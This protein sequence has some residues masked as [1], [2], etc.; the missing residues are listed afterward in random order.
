MQRVSPSTI[1]A[2][3]VAE[4]PK[5]PHSLGFDCDPE[6]AALVLGAARGQVP[7]PRD[8]SKHPELF[9]MLMVRA[10]CLHGQLDAFRDLLQLSE[11][12]G[13]VKY[14]DAWTAA[15]YYPGGEALE[16]LLDARSFPEFESFWDAMHSAPGRYN[17]EVWLVDVH[18]D[19]DAAVLNAVQQWSAGDTVHERGMRAFFDAAFCMGL[20]LCMVHAVQAFPSLVRRPPRVIVPAFYH[21][22]VV[23]RA[24]T[25]LLRCSAHESQSARL[26]VQTLMRDTKRLELLEERE[27]H[28]LQE[29]YLHEKAALKHT[30]GDPVQRDVDALR[31][32]AS[33]RLW[34]C[35]VQQAPNAAQRV[36]KALEGLSEGFCTD[37]DGDHARI[38]RY[39]LH[40][41]RNVAMAACDELGARSIHELPPVPLLVDA[42]L[43]AMCSMGGQYSVRMLRTLSVAAS[44]S[45]DIRRAV[46]GEAT[47]D[48]GASAAQQHLPESALRAVLNTS[49]VR[50]QEWGYR[51]TSQ[52][53]DVYCLFICG[54]GGEHLP[55][56]QRRVDAEWLEA[57]ERCGTLLDIAACL[58][59]GGLLGR[60]SD[61]ELSEEIVRTLCGDG[62]METACR[63][64]G[65]GITNDS[66]W[67]LCVSS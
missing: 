50:A 53:Q 36:H 49:L 6:L 11:A 12:A 55:V 61:C 67:P 63:K 15:M 3:Q 27:R 5:A 37:K 33:C 19:I 42:L 26:L 47:A 44:Q 60:Y 7:F 45:G 18:P 38:A 4:A 56:E 58:Q 16:V 32:R 1:R 17:L 9:L 28:Q 22:G 25:G 48:G 10:A 24:V 64:A 23:K 52:L 54:R 35:R 59:T 8:L 34:L 51:L 41:L 20:P 13:G 39:K 62:D 66:E 40:A 30:G 2:A 29:L 46:Q 65:E 14:V 43:H 21:G 57:A 31:S